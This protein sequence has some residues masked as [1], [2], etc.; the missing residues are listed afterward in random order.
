MFVPV[1]CEAVFDVAFA[2]V[3][4][5][6]VNDCTVFANEDTISYVEHCRGVLAAIDAV[7]VECISSDQVFDELGLLGSLALER[8]W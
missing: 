7:R 5:R 3:K 4:L 2:H 6:P 1:L 8:R